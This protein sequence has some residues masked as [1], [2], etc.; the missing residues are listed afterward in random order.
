MN[1]NITGGVMNIPGDLRYTE[2][3]EW[4]RLEKKIVIIG[5]TDFAQ[6]ELGDIVYIE[7]PDIGKK[8]TKG[9]SLGTIEAVKA[10][11]DIYSPISGE[12]IEVNLDLKNN[13]EHINKDP[14]GIGWM[15]KIAPENPDELQNLMDHTSYKKYLD[16]KE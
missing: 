12:V 3:H 10:A 11:A 14:Y 5:I 7:L 4:V 8:L 6:S 1:S 2:E 9:I 16:K 13:P 15:V